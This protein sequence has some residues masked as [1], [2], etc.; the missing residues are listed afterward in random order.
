MYFSLN[1]NAGASILAL[2]RQSYY[3]SLLSS[4]QTCTDEELVRLAAFSPEE[5]EEVLDRNPDLTSIL[6]GV[7]EPSRKEL[8]TSKLNFVGAILLL[9]HLEAEKERFR[10]ALEKLRDN[11]AAEIILW[12]PFNAFDTR[13]NSC[14]QWTDCYEL[15]NGYVD[16]INDG[17]DRVFM[18]QTQE[19]VKNIAKSPVAFVSLAYKSKIEEPVKYLKS[20]ILAEIRKSL[21]KAFSE[22][23][24][25][26]APMAI[27][28]LVPEHMQS[29]LGLKSAAIEWSLWK[30][31]QDKILQSLA[32]RYHGTQIKAISEPFFKGNFFKDLLDKVVAPIIDS[33]IRLKEL[34]RKNPTDA[35][36]INKIRAFEHLNNELRTAVQMLV[37][38]NLLLLEK[39]GSEQ[40]FSVIET[41]IKDKICEILMRAESSPELIG[42]RSE[43]GLIFKKGSFML[44]AAVSAPLLLFSNQYRDWISQGTSSCTRSQAAIITAEQNAAKLAPLVIPSPTSTPA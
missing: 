41:K 7:K 17:L 36:L 16:I 2:A 10:L 32:L 24:K 20:Q 18:L 11:R 13:T 6:S 31:C 44:L 42:V 8:A 26:N 12:E 27:P 1:S 21:L 4:I 9:E 28:S 39:L 38:T 15:V 33:Q 25:L 34:S 23:Q 43:I 29:G 22:K 35:S 5:L 14:Q 40:G 37:E 3:P 19:K 30:N